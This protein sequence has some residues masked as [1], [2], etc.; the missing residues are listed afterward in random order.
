MGPPR[1][2]ESNPPLSN[3]KS[4][5]R[6]AFKPY[7]LRDYKEIKP[8]KYFSL[9]G[10]GANVG[11][12]EWRKQRLKLDRMTEYSKVRHKMAEKVLARGAKV[13]FPLKAMLPD[14]Q[15]A[16]KKKQRMAEYSKQVPRPKRVGVSYSQELRVEDVERIEPLSELE[17]LEQ[18]HNDHLEQVERLKYQLN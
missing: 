14:Q 6:D 10:L 5:H 17:K 12:D 11:G 3:P 7:T 2:P 15:E 1:P 16:L 18:Q 4:A 13:A 9:G 8:Q